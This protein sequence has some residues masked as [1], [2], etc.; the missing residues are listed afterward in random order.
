MVAHYGAVHA[1]EVHYHVEE[2]LCDSRG[3]VRV[4]DQDEVCILAEAVDDGDDHWLAIDTREPFNEVHCHVGPD[5][6]GN[7]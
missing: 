4:S 2:G 3:G 7:L 6:R 5:R 1:V